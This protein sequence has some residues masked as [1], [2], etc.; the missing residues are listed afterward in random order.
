[1]QIA[2]F[3][4]FHGAAG[5]MLLASLLDTGLELAAL[6]RV[7]AELPLRG[8]T[9]EHQRTVSHHVSGSWLRV[10][11]HE[12]QPSRSWADI[13][14]LLAA[15][16]L[17]ERTRTWAHA[18]FARLARAEARIHGTPVEAVHFHEVGA[19]D[20][21][22]DM[23]GFCAGLELLSV[24]HVYASSL[25]VGHGWVATQHGALPVPAPATLALLAEVGAP[26]VP[27]PVAGE[28]LT[29]TAA[30]LLCEM[31]RF[32][33]PALRVQQVGYGFGHKQFERL[34]GLR[35]W[36]G[37]ALAEPRSGTNAAHHAAHHEHTHNH[38]T[39]HEQVCELR[40]NLDD[41]TGELLAYVVERL[42]AAGALDAWT[43]P[44][45]MKKGRPASLL[46]CLARPADVDMLAALL[47][48]ETPTLGVRWQIME[49]LAAG[50]A[51]VQVETPWGA[52]RLKQKLL[53]GQVTASTPE[54]EDCAA[55]ARAH[56]VPLAEVYR[57]ALHAAHE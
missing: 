47:L 43:A 28:L 29:P 45:V 21:I 18:A 44:L 26:V 9:L 19:V 22:V 23:V 37:T 39:H 49:R 5:D 51:A 31:A 52:V 30:A 10:H 15:G 46:A 11:V 17:P 33:Q 13:Q 8:Y 7:L 56:Q 32:E 1:M 27:A 2:Y 54:Y 25:P 20:S 53:N 6:E 40:C 12:Q 48:R 38:A 55:L 50:R 14:T 41:A 57:A 42:L 36:L 16:S 4:C 34:N 3:D 24:E 35:V